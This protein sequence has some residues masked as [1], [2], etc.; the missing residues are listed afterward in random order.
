MPRVPRLFFHLR[1]RI[2]LVLFV[3]AVCYQQHRFYVSRESLA[4]K[5][6]PTNFEAVHRGLSSRSKKPDVDD[7]HFRDHILSQ[8]EHWQ[9][10]GKGWEGKV[11]S[12]K[13]SVIK[14]YTSGRSPFRNCAPDTEN[15]GEKWPT[16]IAASLR[17]GGHK[18]N[19]PGS[20]LTD[21][22]YASTALHGFLPVKSYFKAA[23][24]EGQEAE[25]HL[26][27]P[28][29]KG[30]TLKDLAKKVAHNPK[31]TKTRDM[32]AYF[33]PIFENLLGDIQRLH[34]A[35]YCHDDIKPDNVF[36]ANRTDWVLG[37]LGNLRHL[38][39][40]YHSSKIWADNNQLSDCRANDIMR[41]LKSYMHFLKQSTNDDKAFNDAF[42][43]GKEPFSRL[44]WMASK[45]APDMS[46]AI[47]RRISMAEYPEQP[48]KMEAAEEIAVSVKDHAF[49]GWFFKQSSLN[50]EVKRML[51]MKLGDKSARWW[52]MVGIFGIPE[53]GGCGF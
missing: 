20:E 46:A 49:S 52:G 50:K 35:K 32:D 1:W 8:R 25:W 31:L 51:E 47:L 36:I 26:V 17:F 30:G 44:F 21:D 45:D 10:L 43:E 39:H 53:S 41:L 37:D 6:S 23:V 22:D 29:L 15:A 13:T 33:R 27:T 40:P 12:Y 4:A 7:T 19:T 9:T 38:S 24:S 2:A 42:M 18:H 14:T 16:E 28:L 48:A 34:D 5:Y 11:F 3:T